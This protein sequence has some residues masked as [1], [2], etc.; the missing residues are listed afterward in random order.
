[1]FV[2]HRAAKTGGAYASSKDGGLGG[3]IVPVVCGGCEYRAHEAH[4]LI[5]A[6]S[7]QRCGL[8]AH[9]SYAWSWRVVGGVMESPS[10]LRWRSESIKAHLELERWVI[11]LLPNTQ[12][13]LVEMHSWSL[14]TVF[15]LV[16]VSAA[17][18]VASE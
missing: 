7:L 16:A 9:E 4:G 17:L 11:Q 15:A 18:P 3:A 5:W 14:L 10:F 6:G 1:M 13:I 12:R 2:V 8:C